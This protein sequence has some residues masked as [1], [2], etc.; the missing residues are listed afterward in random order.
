ME[1]RDI[2]YDAERAG[3]RLALLG[4]SIALFAAA[5]WFAPSRDSDYSLAIAAAIAAYALLGLY[6]RRLVDNAR[7]EP[8]IK[9]GVFTIDIATLGAVF[10]FAPLSDSE[11]VPQIFAFRSFGVHYFLVVLGGAALT[12]SPRLL[13]YCGAVIVAVWWSAFG[14]VVAGMD[15]RLTWGD[16]DAFGYEALVLDPD[17][18]ASGNRVEESL[19]VLLL[20][21]LLALA[22]ARAR[23][24]VERWAESDADRRRAT[25]LFGRFV[26]EAVVDRMLAGPH[27]L[28]PERRTATALFLDIEG[29]TR[30]VEQRTPEQAVEVLNDFLETAERLIAAEGGVITNIQGDA[31]LAAFNAPDDLPDHAGRALAAARRLLDAADSQRFGGARL[32]VRIGVNTGPVAV[33]VVGGGSRRV[34]TMHGDTVNLAAR[35]EALNKQRGTRLL[36]SEAAYRAADAPDGFE[37]LGAATVRGVAAPVRVFGLSRA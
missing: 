14:Y 25:A 37:D 8:W 27:D 1:S 15:R 4:R 35:L 16:L 9:Y 13:L 3:L 20:A 12:L 31:V 7:V 6:L 22:V 2:L 36:A 28:K 33:G 21:A 18:I 24:A 32:G 34:Y 30:L 10:A 11:T 26:P 17:F 5:L 29:F 19:A 23:S